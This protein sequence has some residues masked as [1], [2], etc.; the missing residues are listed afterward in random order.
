MSLI[1][2]CGPERFGGKVASHAGTKTWSYFTIQMIFL[3]SVK[4]RKGNAKKSKG[5]D[6]AVS[7]P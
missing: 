5:P 1:I 6:G 2:G 7:S 4:P 3:E